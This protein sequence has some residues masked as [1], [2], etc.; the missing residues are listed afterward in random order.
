MHIEEEQDEEDE[1]RAQPSDGD[2]DE[3]SDQTEVFARMIAPS[4]LFS[5]MFFG[6]IMTGP[7][8]LQS[9]IEEKQQRIA[10][11][12]L[13][14]VSPF[15]LMAGKLT[16]TVAVGLSVMA[17]Y[18]GFG[19]GGLVHLGY[20]QLFPLTQVVLFL[21]NLVVAMVMYGAIF[22]MVGAA[23]N[24]IKDAQGMMTPVL[25]VLFVP[26]M[27]MQPIMGEPDGMLALATSMFPLSAPMIMPFRMSMATV[28]T[29]Q[30]AVSLLGLVVATAGIIWAAGRVFRI[31]ILARGEVPSLRELLGWI[32]RG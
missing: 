30:I 3:E 31:G 25:L 2:E 26:V 1:E 28:P 4:V 17:V 5:L 16:G 10:E 19:Y 20:A 12:L 14:S 22:L 15:E 24:E 9:T 18:I 23:A 11:V 32:R 29:W 6:V 8:L 13:G 7:Q 27:M 21:A